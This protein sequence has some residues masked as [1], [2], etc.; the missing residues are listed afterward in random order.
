MKK[1]I[2]VLLIAILSLTLLFASDFMDGQ[3]A[4]QMQGTSDASGAWFLAGC[5]CGL[6]GVGA[7]YFMPGTVPAQY[8]VG[9]S[10]EYIIGYTDAYKKAKGKKQATN[11][12]VGLGVYIIVLFLGSSA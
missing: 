1:L 7:A 9:Q 12:A 11:A 2:M 3:M 8:V 4:G 5:G 6:L 10:S